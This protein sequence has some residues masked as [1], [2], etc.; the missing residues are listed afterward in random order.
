MDEL[1]ETN[2]RIVQVL[3]LVG[4]QTPKPV[5]GN[6]SIQFYEVIHFVNA[7]GPLRWKL[8]PHILITGNAYSSH[9]IGH[10]AFRSLSGAHLFR[11]AGLLFNLSYPQ[12]KSIHNLLW[13]LGLAGA[14][15]L[16]QQLCV[17]RKKRTGGSSSRTAT[18][19]G[20]NRFCFPEIRFDLLSGVG[21]VPAVP[22]ESK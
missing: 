2:R 11:L 6:S 4:I 18:A 17:N 19:E 7:S 21:A 9:S 22:G 5:R 15:P 20:R 14:A 13:H 8:R 16:D 1:A 12:A 3:F 10:Y